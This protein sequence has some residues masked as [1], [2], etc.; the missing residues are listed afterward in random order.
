MAAGNFFFTANSL[1]LFVMI[2]SKES[3]VPRCLAVVNETDDG[4]EGVVKEFKFNEEF[5]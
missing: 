2:N 4:S 1:S 5:H 3:G